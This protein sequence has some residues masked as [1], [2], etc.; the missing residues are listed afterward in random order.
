[1]NS[2]KKKPNS[3]RPR[4]FIQIASY[5][6]P[7]CQWTVK[8]LFEKAAHPERL[9]V[10]ICWQFVKGEDDAFFSVPYP[11]PQQV[12]VHEVDARQSKGVC[13]ARSLTQKLWKGE[14]FT[15]Q[16]DSHMRFEPGWDEAL[17]EM[18]NAC[19]HEKAILTCYPPGYKLPNE[20]ERGWIFGMSAKEFDKDGIF[21]MH[22]QPAYTP[23]TAPKKPMR[24]AFASACMYFG[25]SSMIR[26][27]PYDPY[28]YFFGEEISLAVRFWTHGY[29]LFHPNRTVIYHC[30]ER[31]H[32]KTHFDDHDWGQMNDR[33]FRRVRHMLGTE[34][35]SDPNI[36][37]DLD[38]Y[39]LGSVRSLVAYQEYSGVNFTAKTINE[40]AYSG[41]YD[42]QDQKQATIFV[43]I[44]SYRDRECQWTV[45]DLFDK[46]K[47]PDRITVGICWQ[48][49][50]QADQDCFQ[51]ATRENQVRVIPFRWQESEGVCWARH[52]AQQLWDGE[53]YSLQIDAHTRFVQDWDELMIAE[54]AA[55]TSAKPVLSGNPAMYTPPDVREQIPRSSIRR[56]L[57]FTPDGNIIS[58][59]EWLEETPETPLNAA[60]ICD[61]FVF[62]RASLL[63][64][65][66]IDPCMYFDQEE[67]AYSIRVYTHG[68]DVFSSRKPLVYHYYNNDLSKSVRPLHW[69]DLRKLDEKKIDYF[70]NRGIRRFNHL[71]GFEWSKDEDITHDFKRYDVGIRRTL[72]QFEFY[73]GIDFR[74]RTVS[75]KALRAQFIQGLERYRKRS[76]YVPELDNPAIVSTIK[77]Q[78]E[79]ALQQGI[80]R[81]NPMAPI[82]PRVVSGTATTLSAPATAKVSTGGISMPELPS[83]LTSGGHTPR[84]VLQTKEATVYDD[85]LPEDLYWRVYNY[86]IRT[87]YERINTHGKVSR[88]WHIHDQFPLRS[89]LNLYYYA[90]SI[91]KAPAHYIY[92][93]KTDM[94]LFMEQI[95]S[96]S[97]N[98]EHVVGV[99][100]KDWGHVTATCWLYPQ[101]TGLAMHDDGSGTYAGAYAYFLNPVW[102]SSWGG[103]NIMMDRE[104]NDAVYEYR[105]RADQLEFYERGWLDNS[106]LEELLL[107]HGMGKCIFPKKNRIV[108]IHN[109][110]Y[111]MVTRVNEAAGDNIRM[112][113]AGF[114]N[115]K[116]VSEA[117]AKRHDGY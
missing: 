98:Y 17:I 105:K 116:H 53:D 87:E 35:S 4:I 63:Y 22:G 96:F 26:N 27:V 112:S 85:F 76:I 5:R 48:F 30:W 102:K 91:K 74:R 49:D 44:A 12:R 7:E 92:P 97:S 14:E 95:V 18:W 69:Q 68:W 61:S 115:Y 36:T 82:V 23:E 8:D 80:N 32:R 75:E 34:I 109:E 1:M 79:I 66:P 24:G 110:A 13:W 43:N 117:E 39:G 54:L 60:F 31:T 101:G 100:D 2:K 84:L 52:Q 16:I 113:I 88:A 111:H 28:L 71:T 77:K 29:D 10:G 89:V 55:C 67:M 25:P 46:A 81:A 11:R 15:L 33:A 90:P 64:E 62:A 70:Y 73:T 40:R 41:L 20:C 78:A 45:K 104:A 72:Q 6:D 42:M 21:L 59:V 99:H 56:A 106:K 103:F 65:V 107:T 50:E 57:P 9:F 58:Q 83:P 108:F 19:H 3:E 47:Y 51:I 86:A 94:D 93:T 114:F 38:I 37:K